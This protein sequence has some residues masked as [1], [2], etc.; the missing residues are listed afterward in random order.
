V[1]FIQQQTDQ[2]LSASTQKRLTL[3]SVTSKHKMLSGLS[4]SMAL[5]TAQIKYRRHEYYSSNNGS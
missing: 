4:S 2:L 3:T 1:K 5:V